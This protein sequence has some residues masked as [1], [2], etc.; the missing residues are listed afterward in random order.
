M[1]DPKNQ[2]DQCPKTDGAPIFESQ[3]SQQFVNIANDFNILDP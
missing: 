2:L 1:I 3:L